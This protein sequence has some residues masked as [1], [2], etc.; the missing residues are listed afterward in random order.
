MGGDRIAYQVLGQGP[1]DLVMT[2]GGF[3]QIDIIWEDP[4]IALFLRTLAS[5]SRLILF[6]RRGT[7]PPT[8]YRP[9]PC[10]R[11]SPT[12]RS[13]SWSWT[14]SAPSGRRSWRKLT[15]GRSHCFSPGP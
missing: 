8:R 10:H 14:R 2:T 13:S 9:I 15:P 7:A 12:P 6:D 11:G 3:S 1:P 5:F 4:G